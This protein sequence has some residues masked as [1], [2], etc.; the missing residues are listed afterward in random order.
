MSCFYT[1][2]SWWTPYGREC[3]YGEFTDRI[4]DPYGYHTNKVDYPHTF[5][6]VKNNETDTLYAAI[7]DPHFDLPEDMIKSLHE[8][9][10]SRW[11]RYYDSVFCKLIPRA[12]DSKAD[13]LCIRTMLDDFELTPESR[14]NLK[15]NI[16]GYML[17]AV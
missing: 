4:Y 16:D 2:Q 1:I 15:L 17:D 13:L 7:N 10:F 14:D 5:Y 12:R 6:N 11:F 9:L 3:I 8:K